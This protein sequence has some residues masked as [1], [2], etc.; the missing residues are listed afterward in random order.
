[1]GSVVGTPQYMS[2]EQAAGRLN[3][4]GPASDV[5]SLGATLYCLLTGKAPFHGRDV[6]RLLK[7]V[8][9]GDFPTP[10]QIDRRISPSL[11]GICLKAM[12]LIP[13]DRYATPRALAEDIEKWLADEPVAAY[14]E[15]PGEWALRWARHHKHWMV[16]G[17]LLLVVAVMI[18]SGSTFLVNAERQ[19]TQDALAETERSRSATKQALDKAQ[20]SETARI[21]AQV[22]SLLQAEPDSVPTILQ[23]LQPVRNEAFPL[24]RRKLARKD[25]PASQAMRI[26]LALLP[27]QPELLEDLRQELLKAKPEEFAM[28]REGLRDHQAKLREPLWKTLQNEDADKAVRFRAACAL[29]GFDPHNSHWPNVADEVAGWL[30]HQNPLVLGTWV[31]MLEPVRKTLLPALT[32]EFRESPAPEIRNV[33]NN[34]VGRWAADQ[35][36]LLTQLLKD[37]NAAQ[38]E[39]LIPQLR[40][41]KEQALAHFRAALAETLVPKWPATPAG[42]SPPEPRFAEQI[43]QAQ[44]LLADEFALVQTVPLKQFPELAEGLKPAGYRPV[45]YRPYLSR[46]KILVAAVW[47]RDGKPFRME[48]SLTK[49]A[50]LKQNEIHQ[51]AGFAPVD[52]AGYLSFKQS[53][54]AES[55]NK[56]TPNDNPER[57]GAIWVRSDLQT[58]EAR[59]LCGMDYAGFGKTLAQYKRQSNSFGQMT[60]QL[61]QAEKD[62]PRYSSVLQVRPNKQD[63]RSLWGADQQFF[64]ITE[65]PTWVQ[66]EICLTHLD[67][68][69]GSKN[70]FQKELAEIANGDQAAGL[71]QTYIRP[72]KEGMIALG[73]GRNERAVELLTQAINT[74][75]ILP[76]PYYLRS[77]AYA[78]LGKN[79]EAKQDG[80]KAGEA[81]QRAIPL[82]TAEQGRDFTYFEAYSMS[83]VA[84][85]LGEPN[86]GEKQLEDFLA[87]HERQPEALYVAARAY[88]LMSKVVAENKPGNAPE[89]KPEDGKTLAKRYGD[90]A[91]AMLRSAYQ[92]GF[93]DTTGALFTQ[94][95]FA[96]IRDLPAYHQLVE[97][98]H[99]MR[100]FALVWH[101]GNIAYES[102]RTTGTSPQEHLAECRRLL[103]EGFRPEAISV[104]TPI[105]NPEGKPLLEAEQNPVGIS[106]WQRPL[107]AE[108]DR[109]Q[110]ARQQANSAL[111][112]WRLDPQQNHWPQIKSALTPRFDAEFIN[113][114]ASMKL[115]PK[116]LIDRL[117]RETNPFAK[118]ILLLAL[119]NYESAELSV[120]ERQ[121]LI[122]SLAAIC[123]DDPDAGIHSA[124]EWLLRTWS[125][126]TAIETLKKSLIT[127]RPREGKKWYVNGQGQTLAVVK[128]P[129]EFEMGASPT[130]ADRLTDELMHR[131]R[132]DRTFAIATTETTVSQF[133]GFN[134]DADFVKTSSPDIDGPI[135]NVDWFDAVR[136]CRWLSEKEGIPEDQMCYPALEEIGPGMTMPANYLKRTGYRLPTE[137]E[138]EFAARMGQDT[139]YTYGDDA[140]LL[141]DRAWIMNNANDRAHRVGLLKPNGLGLFD[142]MGNVG[143]W[144]HDEYMPYRLPP[145]GLA[146]WDIPP[147]EVNG[148]R[149]GRGGS[150]LSDAATSRVTRRFNWNSTRKFT[151]V[152]FRIARTLPPAKSE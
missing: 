127:N 26:Q 50:L 83:L 55:S 130:D 13:G 34:L 84:A 36:E 41:H 110:H 71:G 20:A 102:R 15:T 107:I 114:A 86:A 115:P 101:L 136:Y 79:A 139:R 100:R 6:G 31:E 52:V 151:D 29:A 37:A 150:L 133:L 43:D 146:T 64:E 14:R 81:Q 112:L 4:L 19:R 51:K 120:A 30:V 45:R 49:E 53:S 85:H 142:V 108:K 5:Y 149:V 61:F 56:K 131:V 105:L 99:A 74:V 82:L 25:L 118:R 89:S 143:E 106:V 121:T 134:P 9:D 90:R 140:Q 2:P 77:L 94:P 78:R 27:A 69:L 137:A 103:A 123:R 116:V 144:C 91:V 126:E 57:Y 32:R 98:Q 47:R 62:Q 138:W 73:E 80:V 48:T 122:P 21:E 111:A 16:A 39:A 68:P 72:Y 23:A 11:E 145:R 7:Q 38:F 63:W 24:L 1:M 75:K 59:L 3:Q 97:D 66:N 88:A 132:I 113:R 152:G 44:G 141:P 42:L 148:G 58:E 135:I 109:T 119:G 54:A 93:S 40:A 10:R 33:A 46:G 124:A 70:P 28:L 22:N 65:T 147:R 18:L 95:D 129:A 35:L 104:S 12:A 117:P 128:G 92:N 125:N 67:Q 96:P 17:T 60:L 76:Q 87:A 8:Q